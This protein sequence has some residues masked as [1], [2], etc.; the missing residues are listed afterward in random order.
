M[1]RNAPNYYIETTDRGC[2]DAELFARSV[3]LR[4]VVGAA[5]LQSIDAKNNGNNN[6]WGDSGVKYIPLIKSSGSSSSSSSS[7]SSGASING[8]ITLPIITDDDDN[9]VI[10]KKISDA[11]ATILQLIQTTLPQVTNLSSLLNQSF[12]PIIM[13]CITPRFVP[14]CTS[15]MMSSL[16]ALSIKYGLPVQSHLSESIS[17][18]KWVADLYPDCSNYASVYK[19]Y[20]LLNENVY[21]AHCVHC[22]ETERKLLN[23]CKT[24]MLLE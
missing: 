18:I 5:Y 4:T 20:G 9:T 6:D 21:M 14:T 10:N 16:S 13:P 1:D 3:L 8:A 23:S 15:E 12:T 11:N 17:E 24:G 7:S 2:Y 19:K 22:D